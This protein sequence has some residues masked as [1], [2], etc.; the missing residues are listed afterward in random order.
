MKALSPDNE[1]KEGC[2]GPFEV[3]EYLILSLFTARLEKDQ[4]D[5]F[6]D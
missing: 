5:F 4:K 1:G 2:P 6:Q 3:W